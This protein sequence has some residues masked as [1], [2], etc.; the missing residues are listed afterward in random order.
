MEHAGGPVA[1]VDVARLAIILEA[2]LKEVKGESL[3]YQA[4]SLG[5]NLYAIESGLLRR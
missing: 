1:G 5:R 2:T 4:E 3:A